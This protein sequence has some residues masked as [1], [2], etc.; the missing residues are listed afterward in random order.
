MSIRKKIWLPKRQPLNRDM[1]LSVLR[2]FFLQKIN[3][4]FVR[5]TIACQRSTHQLRVSVCSPP[6]S[7]NGACHRLFPLLNTHH[8]SVLSKSMAHSTHI[9]FKSLSQRIPNRHKQRRFFKTLQYKPFF[10]LHNLVF[11][12]EFRIWVFVIG[13]I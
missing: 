8:F 12:S 1:F 5:Y 2:A 9:N 4:L 11:E 3:F 6:T 13:H 7:L 10:Q